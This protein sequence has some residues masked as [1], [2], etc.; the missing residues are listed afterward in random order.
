[1]GRDGRI[2]VRIDDAG[3]VWIGGACVTVAHGRLET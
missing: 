2:E 3:D 1:V